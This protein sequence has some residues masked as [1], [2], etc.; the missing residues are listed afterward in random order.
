MT[1]KIWQNKYFFLFC[2][3][4]F[5][6]LFMLCL[7]RNAIL[8]GNTVHSYVYDKSSLFSSVEKIYDAV[9]F[10][11][12]YSGSDGI[13]A[14]TG[15]F[16]KKDQKYGYILTNEHVI[17]DADKVEIVL[18]DDRRI[19]S[20]ILGKDEYLDLAVLRVD[21]KNVSLVAMI[22]DSQ[23]A[24][25]GDNVFTVGSPLGYSY[26]GSVTS[27]VLSGKDRMVSLNVYD[28]EENNWVMKVLQTDL[29]MNHGSSGGPLVNVSGEVIGICTMR[30]VNDNADGMG[31][32]I[33]IEFAMKYV[34]TLETEDKIE[35]P[36]LGIS[37]VNASDREKISVYDLEVPSSVQEGVV[38]LDVKEDGI[39]SH[40]GLEKG[41]VITKVGKS[42]IKD[43]AYLRYELYQ[44]KK[45]EEVSITYLRHGKTVTKKVKL[46]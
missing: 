37:M 16:Y 11:D 36:I 1:K 28:K 31:F 26:R 35:W 6:C 18:S 7:F 43:M 46:S 15:F 24:Q 4:L 23:N 25:L 34:D 30:L 8:K 20:K 22:G 33:P 39:A 10:V 44:Y 12:A 45:G 2:A 32:A 27:G 3:F 17:R 5:G 42:S 40:M 13:G 21:K 9:V 19:E 29:P 14:G 41:D 38:I